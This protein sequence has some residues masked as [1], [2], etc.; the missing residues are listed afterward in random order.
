MCVGRRQSTSPAW[1]GWG[2][3]GV[4][5]LQN[6][7]KILL[8]V[9][10]EEEPEPRPQAALFLLTVPPLSHSQNRECSLPCLTG[11]GNGNLLQ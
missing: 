7:F 2:E 10:L 5:Y 9:L 4:R 11:E 8:C 3:G 6:C 1:Q